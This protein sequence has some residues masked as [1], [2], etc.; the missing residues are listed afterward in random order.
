MMR[1]AKERVRITSNTEGVR[2]ALA[3]PR[4][5]AGQKEQQV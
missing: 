5:Y 2:S 4:E 1:Q 3:P